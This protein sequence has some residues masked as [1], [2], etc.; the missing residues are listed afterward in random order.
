MS[1][2]KPFPEKTGQPLTDEQ[3][4]AITEWF[5]VAGHNRRVEQGAA[6]SE[7]DFI[8]GAMTVFFALNSQGM[9][10]AGWVFGPLAG[11]SLFDGEGE[12]V[13]HVR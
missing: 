6:F 11:R 5:W 2:K 3:L 8:A 7:V 12:E 9:M 1:T 4:N 13:Q 10:P